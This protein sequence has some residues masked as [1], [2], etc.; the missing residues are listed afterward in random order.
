MQGLY[1]AEKLVNE[2]PFPDSGGSL[3]K[4]LCIQECRNKPLC[5]SHRRLQGDCQGSQSLT[6]SV[7]LD[8]IKA[9][10]PLHLLHEKVWAHCRIGFRLEVSTSQ[11]TEITGSRQWVTQDAIALI[12]S[13][14][15]LHGNAFFSSTGSGKP[16]RMHL[17]GNSLPGCVKRSLIDCELPWQ[18]EQ[19]KKILFD[20]GLHRERFAAAASRLFI[21][22]SKLETLV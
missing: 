6:V 11:L 18:L 5:I 20:Q 4:L 21:R 7:R 17:Q 14:T 2:H 12:G 9:L 1:L 8:V 3:I 19:R 13:G 15:P 22:V 10:S 16:I